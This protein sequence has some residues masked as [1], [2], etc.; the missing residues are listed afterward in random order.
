MA[1]LN[2]TQHNSTQ[3]QL[4]TNIVDLPVDFKT[5]LVAAITFPAVYTKTDLESAAGKVYELVRD[6]VPYLLDGFEGAMIGGMP[7]FM[8]VLEATLI[9]KGIR[10]GYACTERQ[11]IDKEVDGKIIKTAVFVHAGMYWAN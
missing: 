9:S 4:A 3:D 7:S 10:V 1:I 6:Y 8:P 5:A 2:L 11:S